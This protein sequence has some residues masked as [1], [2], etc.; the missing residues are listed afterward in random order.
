MK[1]TAPLFALLPLLVVLSDASKADGLIADGQVV[2][3]LRAGEV[4][5]HKLDTAAGTFGPIK[6]P[7]RAKLF[8]VVKNTADAFAWRGPRDT[9]TLTPNK[10]MTCPKLGNG[11]WSVQ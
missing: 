1:S 3:M 6:R 4:Y 11:T 9:C 5:K 2:V 10:R 7:H 8:R